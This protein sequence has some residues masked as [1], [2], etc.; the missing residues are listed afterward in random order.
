MQSNPSTHPEIPNLV[1]DTMVDGT[2]RRVGKVTDVVS[3]P[4]TLEAEWLVVKTSVFG[5]ERLVPME[6]ATEEGHTTHIEFS[7][8][9]VLSAPVPEV[10]TS[11]AVYE[12][13]A[14]VEH[15]HHAA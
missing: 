11:L 13:D 10:S 8:D 3:R 14:L 6:A 2:G 7:R 4:E 12:R 15:Y 1:G 9:D 5:R